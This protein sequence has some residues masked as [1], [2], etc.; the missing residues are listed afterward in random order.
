MTVKELLNY[1][2]IESE[3]VNITAYSVLI[4]LLILVVSWVVIRLLRGLFKRLIRKERLDKGA[5]WSVYLII[6]YFF[7]VIVILLVLDTFGVRI[8]IFLASIAALLVGVGLGL[9]QLFND[10]ASGII[11]LIERHVK[12]GDVLQL[13]DGTVGRVLS[14]GVRTS[15]IKTRD[16]VIETIPNSS[17][18]NDKVIN[19]SLIEERTR[20]HV[21]VGV[22]YGS[23]VRLVEKILLDCAK[24]VKEVSSTPSPFVRFNDFGTSSLDF[25]L[26][27]WVNNSF[28]VEHIKSKLRFLIDDRF[29]ENGVT[30]PFPQRDVHIKED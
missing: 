9:Q 2:I 1:T 17:F 21:D 10:I 8:S 19:W 16:D 14:I 6:K 28:L 26:Y 18:V 30:I 3:N 4:A 7:W 25:Q 5:G 11:I 22:A 15:R 23:D 13:E 20:F 27:F 29:R 12:V 24:E